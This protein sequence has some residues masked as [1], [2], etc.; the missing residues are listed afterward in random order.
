MLKDIT[1]FEF[2][3]I[4]SGHDLSSVGCG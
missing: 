4:A 1:D 2:F 3:K